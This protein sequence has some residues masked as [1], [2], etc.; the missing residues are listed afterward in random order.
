MRWSFSLG[1]VLGSDL[2]VHVTFLL[3]LAWVAY[4]AFVA[5]GWSLALTDTLFVV[6]L[7]ACVVAH[8]FGHALAARRFGIRTPD[9]TLLP[10][11]GLARLERMPENPRQEIIV[12]LAGPAVNV[13]IAIVIYLSVGTGHRF[14]AFVGMTSPEADFFVRLASVNLLL[15]V[16]NLIPAFPMDGG[17]VLRA[18]LSLFVSRVRATRL[19]AIAG[20]AVAVALGFAGLSFG[21]PV[22]VL[23]AAFVFFAANAES[24]EVALQAVA[25]RMQ[26]RDAMITQ[27]EALSPDDTVAA[28]GAALV[29]TTQH[30]F[31]VIAANGELAGF[32]TRQAIF[33][34]RA[35]GGSQQAGIMSIATLDIPRVALAD[36]LEKALNG[37]HGGAPAVAVC[38]AD[39]SVVGYITRENIGEIMVLQGR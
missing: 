9:I 3:L 14:D 39:G 33:S 4:A 34:D 27:F 20:Q 31:P 16:F 36:G 19:A 12:A 1:R 2:R 5:G 24:N 8:E 17:R 6:A 22:L 15:A 30:E 10:I 7:F 21:N 32:V 28:A 25:R 11:G 23:I 18:T 13:V 38:A 29:R 26:A 35:Q 37:L